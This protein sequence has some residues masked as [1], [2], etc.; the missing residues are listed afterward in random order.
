MTELL[1][2]WMLLAIIPAAIAHTRGLPVGTWFLYG[3]LLWPVA[4]VHVFFATPNSV[5]L[6]GRPAPPPRTCPFCAEVIQSSA[7]VCKH[8]RRDL[9]RGSRST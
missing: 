7:I 4:V 3:L 2:G 5:R 1:L 8:C 6:A 9:P